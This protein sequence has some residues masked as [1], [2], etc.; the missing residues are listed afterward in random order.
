MIRVVN[1]KNYFS[2]GEYI[3]RPSALGNPFSHLDESKAEFRVNS[4]QEAIDAWSDWFDAQPL[5]S[6]VK[7]EFYRLCD[8]YIKDGELTLICWCAPLSC[9]GH[10]LAKKIQDYADEV[11]AKS[12]EAFDPFA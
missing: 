12:K 9:H 1:R 6:E 2:G 10:V 8:K 5:H 11:N 4:R 3:G 7:R